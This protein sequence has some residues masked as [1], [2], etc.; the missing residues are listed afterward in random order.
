MSRDRFD[1]LERF[2][3]LFEAPEPS[4]EGLLRRRDR[5]RRNE[6]IVAGVVGIAL[7][8]TPIALFAGLISTDRAQKPGTPGATEQA[9]P[10]PTGVG[11][12]GLPPEGAPP[13]TPEHGQL[14]LDFRFG[15]TG[16]DPGRFSLQVYAD[17]RVIWQR[18]S[19]P[20]TGLIEQRLTPEGVE[21]VLAEILST[22]FFDRDRE[23]VGLPGRFHYGGIQVR[24]GDRLVH[25]TWGNAGF[26]EGE[27]PIATTATPEQVRALERLDARLEDLASWLPTSAWEDPELR[28]Y[29]PFRYVVCYSGQD[30]AIQRPRLLDLLPAPAE[31]LLS[32]KATNVDRFNGPY[33][34]IPYWCSVLRTEEARELAGILEDAGAS[35]VSPMGPS[36][37]FSP[38]RGGLRVNVSLDPALPDFRVNEWLAAW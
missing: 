21:L 19:V 32:A 22:G 9:S 28:P 3:P 7:F 4:F 1:V 10:S 37:V 11:L 18:L 16:G 14:V 6:R 5:K 8:L 23:F 15:H 20:P 27:D 36:Y 29:V 24:V 2:A 25:L 26:E 31:E 30:E 34:S 33:G 13:S 12:L 35:R 17:G 38:S